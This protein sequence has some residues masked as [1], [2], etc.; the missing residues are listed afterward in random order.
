M[1]GAEAPFLPLFQAFKLSAPSSISSTPLQPPAMR[2]GTLPAAQAWAWLRPRRG[3]FSPSPCLCSGSR[4][5]PP[6]PQER[7]TAASCKSRASWSSPTRQSPQPEPARL[8]RAA[9]SQ[10]QRAGS[11]RFPQTLAVRGA[12]VLLH[13]RTLRPRDGAAV[14]RRAR[15]CTAL[16]VAQGGGGRWSRAEGSRASRVAYAPEVHA[17]A[18]AGGSSWLQSVGVRG[19]GAG[20]ARCA[21]GA[22]QRRAR[23][24]CRDKHIGWEGA[25]ILYDQKTSR[26]QNMRDEQLAS[27]LRLTP[28][29][30]A[31]L[32]QEARRVAPF[33]AGTGERVAQEGRGSFIVAVGPQR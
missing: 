6:A 28:T 14:T 20:L 11:R 12:A 4:R 27:K 30:R 15:R 19:E 26:K 21:A 23:R 33:R 16:S 22:L 31:S 13:G 10:H 24:H 18:D 29:D 25:R 9:A 5:G 3:S 32:E 7:R 17:R 8:L 2:D 1:Y